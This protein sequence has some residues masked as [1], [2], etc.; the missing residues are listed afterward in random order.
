[1]GGKGSKGVKNHGN[2]QSVEPE[3]T[4]PFVSEEMMDKRLL[5]IPLEV[6]FSI[7]GIDES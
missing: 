7:Y 4:S 3:D 2:L 6:G 1:M 5:K